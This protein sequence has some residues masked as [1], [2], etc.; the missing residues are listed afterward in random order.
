MV[1][2]IEGVI[3]GLVIAV[4]L[5]I[6]RYIYKILVKKYGNTGQQGSHSEEE[7]FR[8]YIIVTYKLENHI[9]NIYLKNIGL[10]TATNIIFKSDCRSLKL[11]SKNIEKQIDSLGAGQEIVIHQMADPLYDNG[12]KKWALANNIDAMRKLGVTKDNKTSRPI[13]NYPYQYIFSYNDLEP[14]THTL[15]VQDTENIVETFKA[16]DHKII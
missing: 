3:V 2:I 5:A 7:I 11:C 16:S 10:R 6:I 1:D 13:I 15:I 9:F 12:I 8:P 4:I 14:S